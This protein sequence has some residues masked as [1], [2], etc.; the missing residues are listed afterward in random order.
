MVFLDGVDAMTS[1]S[2]QV[3]PHA[4]DKT[5]SHL[6]AHVTTMHPCA[7]QHGCL[8]MPA[9]VCV[10]GFVVLDWFEGQN[11]ALII[12]TSQLLLIHQLSLLLLLLTTG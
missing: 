4:E 5:H 12:H 9:K 7:L 2:I 8:V 3:R 11:V 10:V 1:N 6:S